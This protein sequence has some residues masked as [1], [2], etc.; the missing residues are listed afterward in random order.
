MFIRTSIT[1]AGL[2]IAVLVITVLARNGLTAYGDS[3]PIHEYSDLG[4]VKD[5]PEYIPG[6]LIVEFAP[7]T[8]P[9]LQGQVLDSYALHL[10][11]RLE[12]TLFVLVEFEPDHGL[13]PVE[14]KG[15]EPLALAQELLQHPAVASAEPNYYRYAHFNPNDTY[16]SYQW[17]F[18]AI[19]IQQAWDQ[20]TGTGATVAVLDT[21]VAYETY[22]T[23]RQAPDL[24]GTTFV[25]GY[26]FVN[27][28]QHPNDDNSHGTHVAGTIAQTT[29]NNM[30]VTGVAFAAKMMSVKVLDAN[31]SGSAWDLAQGIRW[32]TDHGAD[33]INMSL[34]SSSS[35][36]VEQDAVQYAYG[37]GVT[38]VAS[39]G[40]SGTSSV[41]YPAAY[42]EV[43][44]VGAVRY[45]ET[46]ASYSDHGP[47]LDVVAPGGDTSVDQNRDGYG[48]GILQQTFNPS[49]RDVTDFRFYFFQGTSMASPHVAGASALLIAKGVATT[50]DEVRAALESTAK[51][52]GS[53]GRDNTYGHG[54]IQVADALAWNGGSP[55]TPT[56][57]P[58][59]PT[60]TFTPTTIPTAT[61][62]PVDDWEAR[63][64][65]LINIER[66]A[67]GKPPLSID[68][69]LVQAA[70]RHSQDMADNNFFSH[71]GSDG[72][73]PFDRIRT[74]GY[75][76]R[77]AGETIAGGYTS[78]E[79]AVNAWMNS[80][81]HRAILLGNY[82]DV[83]VGYVYKSNS[84]YRH[85]WTA[86]FAIPSGYN[87]T[88]TPSPTPTSTSTPTATPMPSNSCGDLNGSGVIDA[89]DLQMAAA[90][91][92]NGVGSE[93]DLNGDGVVDIRDLMIIAAQWGV[94]CTRN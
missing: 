90:D 10:I 20:S 69:R 43:I 18:P 19:Q 35:S 32:A 60:P 23:Y 21:G 8:G 68:S 1:R 46:L 26:D 53:P 49:T 40:N 13:S 47:A 64:V 72:S 33:V 25:P 71:Y 73:S 52:L 2:A 6:Q 59:G 42:D 82:D 88:A 41:G 63:T 50:P 91:W 55:V 56:P 67:N 34:G 86:D 12:D 16:F 22:G 77:T 39:A 15:Q 92:Q 87:P 74:A 11:D 65:Q 30:G 54:L 36:S 93:S 44:S 3:P 89:D 76:F 29:N 75:S 79:A 58:T 45:D 4:T 17:H 78:P 27:N 38:L 81:G 66:D 31:G 48:D 5:R 28:D 62:T 51:D 85:Y 84:T 83:G 70:R 37:Q 61:S 7:A 24:A 94:Q 14:V 57:T 80:S 9:V